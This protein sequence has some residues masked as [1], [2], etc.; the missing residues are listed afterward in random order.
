MARAAGTL[1]DR[2]RKWYVLASVALTIPALLLLAIGSFPS[3]ADLQQRFASGTGLRVLVGFGIAALLWTGWLLVRLLS[4][5]RATLALPHG[6]ALA[7]IRFRVWTALGGCVVGAL[8]LFRLA[9]GV[10]PDGP[11]IRNLHLLDASITVTSGSGM[12]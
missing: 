7:T 8:L 5:W 2:H 12:S 3:A 10:P 11:V 9:D 1:R 6:E 4:A